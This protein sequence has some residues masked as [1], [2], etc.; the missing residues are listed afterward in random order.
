MN[1]LETKTWQRLHLET[2]TTNQ[3]GNSKVFSKPDLKSNLQVRSLYSQD[4]RIS[5]HKLVWIF[6]QYPGTRFHLTMLSRYT[7]GCH[8]LL[9]CIVWQDLL[10][11]MEESSDQQLSQC[12]LKFIQ[13]HLLVELL[14]QMLLQK[15]YKRIGLLRYL[16]FFPCSLQWWMA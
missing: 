3:S 2:A 16:S 7:I 5:A 10:V 12:R 6:L 13:T 9:L 8:S 1:D 11:S 4:T 15:Y 14:V